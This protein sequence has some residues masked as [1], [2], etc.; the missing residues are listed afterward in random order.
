MVYETG[1]P[2]A[3]CGFYTGLIESLFSLVQ[4]FIMPVW[5]RLS[6]KVRRASTIL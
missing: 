4:F 5:G 1:I 2:A 6:D 3:Q